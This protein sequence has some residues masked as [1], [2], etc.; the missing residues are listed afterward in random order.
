MTP[1]KLTL[2]EL[3]ELIEL[4]DY[5]GIISKNGFLEH[6][7]KGIM[8][9]QINDVRGAVRLTVEREGDGFAVIQYPTKHANKT[10]CEVY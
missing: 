8:P 9:K 7:K 3:L 5:R 10:L 1:K 6:I 2:L 4:E